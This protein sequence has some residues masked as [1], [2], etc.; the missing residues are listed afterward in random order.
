MIK[1]IFYS[2]FIWVIGISFSTHVLNHGLSALFIFSYE[3]W[4]THLGGKKKPNVASSFF[5]PFISFDV[6]AA[7]IPQ[8][9]PQL[10]GIMRASLTGQTWVPKTCN[11]TF[12]IP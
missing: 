2:E 11:F 4:F 6:T 8:L 7:A 12:N 10:F 9:V 5:V 1:Y 3:P